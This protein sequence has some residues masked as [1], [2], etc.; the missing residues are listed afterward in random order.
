[1]VVVVVLQQ[2]QQQQQQSKPNIFS[3]QKATCLLE[4]S[5]F[6][7]SVSTTF[8]ITGSETGRQDQKITKK[9][10]ERQCSFFHSAVHF[11]DSRPTFSAQARRCRSI[12]GSNFALVVCPGP[13]FQNSC[14]GVAYPALFG[15]FRLFRG[16][17]D[18]TFHRAC[19]VNRR[20]GVTCAKTFAW[21]RRIA[22]LTS[23]ACKV[24][25]NR[26]SS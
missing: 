22:F 2:Q 8:Y 10:L 4:E 6:L 7:P 26:R 19:A 18:Y 11:F 13:F 21:L 12:L 17:A 16:A 9:T 20:V 5:C 3:K 1:M 25:L 23:F 15:I 24:L 14:A